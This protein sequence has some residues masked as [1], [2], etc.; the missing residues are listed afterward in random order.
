MR[1]QPAGAAADG[2]GGWIVG[3]HVEVAVW[4][5]VAAAICSTGGSQ[6]VKRLL[7]DK[8]QDGRARKG[9]AQQLPTSPHTCAE[10]RDKG[11][12]PRH[13]RRDHQRIHDGRRCG[14]WIDAVHLR[15]VE[16]RRLRLRRLPAW[17]GQARAEQRLWAPICS[18]AV[19]CWLLV[20][21]PQ[22]SAINYSL[23]C[24]HCRAS[25]GCRS[26]EGKRAVVHL[27]IAASSPRER[28]S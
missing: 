21:R 13:D 12:G 8:Q 14:R 9:A 10:R 2:H 19:G 28:R 5:Q 20:G 15:A 26:H 16:R 7:A 18:T 11:N 25:Y 24:K 27:R 1:P 6:P 17:V 3:Q 23:Y 22:P 4:R